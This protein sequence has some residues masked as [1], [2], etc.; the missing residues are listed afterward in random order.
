MRKLEQNLVVYVLCR[1]DSKNTFDSG[2]MTGEV[3]LNQEVRLGPTNREH[4]CKI[5]IILEYF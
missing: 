3:H 4:V 1:S 5:G 2:S